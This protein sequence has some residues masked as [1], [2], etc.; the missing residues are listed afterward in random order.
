MK[1]YFTFMIK[2]GPISR[3]FVEF[4]GDFNQ[5]RQKMLAEFGTEW[6]FQYSD[7]E[8]LAEARMTKISVEEAHALL[9]QEES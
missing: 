4:E 6:A 7:I 5:S 3:H 8:P 9:D 1:H 2:Q